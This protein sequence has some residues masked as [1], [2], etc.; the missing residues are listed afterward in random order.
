[1]NVL[2]FNV[3]IVV[4][5]QHFK[6]WRIK[7]KRLCKRQAE[8]AEESSKRFQELWHRYTSMKF[9]INRLEYHGLDKS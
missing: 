9:D 4:E 6:A 1:M 8:E 7:G 2:L 5:R 3:Q